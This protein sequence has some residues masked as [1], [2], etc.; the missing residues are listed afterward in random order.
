[1]VT[2]GKLTPVTSRS[3]QPFGLINYFASKK[4]INFLENFQLGKIRQELEFQGVERTLK[5]MKPGYGEFMR[6]Q[7][8]NPQIDTPKEIGDFINRFFK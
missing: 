4:D 2:S 3:F 8:N 5:R 6:I 7:S 1:M